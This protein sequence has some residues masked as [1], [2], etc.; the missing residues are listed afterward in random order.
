M[1]NYTDFYLKLIKQKENN[2][3]LYLVREVKALT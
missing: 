2:M 1:K 3:S